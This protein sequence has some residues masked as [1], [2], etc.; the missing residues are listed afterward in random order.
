VSLTSV[1]SHK[2]CENTA[3]ASALKTSI[4][5]DSFF[6]GQ[7][8]G[9]VI[10]VHSQQRGEEMDE[11]VQALLSVQ[12]PTNPVEIVIHVNILKEGWE[13][14][15]LYMI[16]SLRTANSKPLVEQS[17]GRG[18]RL[19]YG[20]RGGRSVNDRLPRSVLRNY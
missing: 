5:D 4:E 19:P 3:H 2:S 17:I 7:Y 14:T 10:E 1:S 8:K 20:K 15:N 11:N 18:L 13:V 6:G 12:D 9:R 16:V